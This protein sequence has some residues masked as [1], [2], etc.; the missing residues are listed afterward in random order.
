MIVVETLVPIRTLITE[1]EAT[2]FFE[3]G[4]LSVTMD[5][6]QLFFKPI[7]CNTIKVNLA[8]KGILNISDTLVFANGNRYVR[9]SIYQ[10]MLLSNIG[11]LLEPI[12]NHDIINHLF[13]YAPPQQEPQASSDSTEVSADTE[14]LVAQLEMQK[15]EADIDEALANKDE[16][17]FMKLSERLNELKK[18]LGVV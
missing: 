9:L 1:S 13:G 12:L 5:G 17:A 18:H 7:E 3:E 10:L 15:L 11:M 4:S 8:T 14:K 6:E 16:E 2:L